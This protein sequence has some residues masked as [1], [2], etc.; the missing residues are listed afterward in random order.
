[1]D[2]MRNASR[3]DL[4]NLPASAEVSQAAFAR[5]AGVTAR[6]INNGHRGRAAPRWAMILAAVLP[7]F[8]PTPWA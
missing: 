3:Q 6:Q 5:L 8:S 4:T 2:A 1:M 7:E